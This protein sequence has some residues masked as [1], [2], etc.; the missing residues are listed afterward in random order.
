MSN[1]ARALRCTA[2]ENDRG[3]DDADLR[4]ALRNIPV[5]PA[6][7]N[8]E[9]LLARLDDETVADSSG[10]LAEII[11]DARYPDL[12]AS[13]GWAEK[14]DKRSNFFEPTSRTANTNVRPPAPSRASRLLD[15][16]F[17]MAILGAAGLI[18]WN[19]LL[20]HETGLASLTA[21]PAPS[22]RM[23][24]SGIAPAHAPEGQMRM[25]DA[26]QTPQVA[27][28]AAPI[29]RPEERQPDPETP[30]PPVDM[31]G[32]G[33]IEAPAAT[34]PRHSPEPDTSTNSPPG[35]QTLELVIDVP[36]TGELA[37]AEPVSAGAETTVNHPTPLAR[38]NSP[39]GVPFAGIWAVS[40]GACTSKMQRK[41]HLLT[42]VNA[43]RA[44]AGGTVCKFEKTVHQAG[45]WQIAASCSD[46]Q[47]TW[48]S[49]VQ[50]SLVR[51][52]LIWAS[53]KG[54]TTY[55]RCQPI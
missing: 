27:A 8:V 46:G 38:T 55:V 16:L 33:T 28:A 26:I 13:A 14:A 44:R 31:T 19:V 53:E 2:P 5:L 9:D 24:S 48:N 7:A 54:S 25:P 50:L 20:T 41:G 10:D 21:Q 42:Y 12:P 6:P 45:A 22:S 52:R 15:R 1:S 40:P 30:E 32:I 4:T 47:T 11:L 36:V 29:D 3:P 39:A 43:Q 49:N 37:L 34:Q 35:P 18:A 51:G 23:N 17:S